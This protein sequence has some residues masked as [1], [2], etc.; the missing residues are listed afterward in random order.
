MTRELV[1]KEEKNKL[2]YDDEVKS[3]NIRAYLYG[4]DGLTIYDE[5]QIIPQ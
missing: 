3:N 4:F 1:A 5:P 2:G